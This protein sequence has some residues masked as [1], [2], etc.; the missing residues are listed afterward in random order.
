MPLF[1]TNAMFIHTGTI[2]K[3]ENDEELVGVMAHETGHIMG[4][5]ILRRKIKTQNMQQMT[6][7]SMLVAGAAAAAT[8]RGDVAMAVSALGGSSSASRLC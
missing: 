1:L 4:G 2:I 3:S 8:G 7:A 6:L 5:H